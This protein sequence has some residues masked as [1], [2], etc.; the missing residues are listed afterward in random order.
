[1]N[2]IHTNAPAAGLQAHA[3][4]DTIKTRSYL[5][6]LRL[7]L[8]AW[9]GIAATLQAQTTIVWQDNFE[10]ADPTDQWSVDNGI[11]EIGNPTTGPAINSAGYRTHKGT[12]RAS[13]VLAGNY[14]ASTSSRLIRTTPFVV[15]SAILLVHGQVAGY[16]K[17]EGRRRLRGLA[18]EHRGIRRRGPARANAR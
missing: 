15:P 12:N 3:K 11:W 10:R 4:A 9:L 6:P 14:P 8:L 17:L 13:T 18:E 1:M 7:L 16:R 2:N 5:N